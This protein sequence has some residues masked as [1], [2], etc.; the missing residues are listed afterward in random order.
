MSA[1]HYTSEPLS[2][3]LEIFTKDKEY[4][5]CQEFGEI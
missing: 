3:G 2:R 5:I 1:I 4:Y